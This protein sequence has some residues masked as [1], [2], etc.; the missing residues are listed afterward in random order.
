M[1]F[2]MCNRS[3]LNYTIEDAAVIYRFTKSEELWINWI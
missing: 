1:I 3:G 2:L